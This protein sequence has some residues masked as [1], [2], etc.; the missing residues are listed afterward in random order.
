LLGFGAL[1][2]FKRNWPTGIRAPRSAVTS[3][4]S[5]PVPSGVPLVV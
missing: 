5:A 1:L 4:F 3:P 2:L